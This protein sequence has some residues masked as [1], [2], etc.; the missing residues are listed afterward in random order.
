[1]FRDL[2]QSGDELDF[3]SA[4]LQWREVAVKDG[5]GVC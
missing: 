2:W 1:M 4:W 5:F 3:F